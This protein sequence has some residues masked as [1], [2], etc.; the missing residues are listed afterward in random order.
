MPRTKTA[1]KALRQNIRRRARNLSQRKQLRERIK[2]YRA[3]LTAGK[4]AEADAA[5]RQV[6]QALDKLA[7]TKALKRG[8]ANRLKGRFARRL[9][10]A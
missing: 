3:H 6:Y 1:K 8:K 7:K 4:G 5:L 9:R 10:A 2:A